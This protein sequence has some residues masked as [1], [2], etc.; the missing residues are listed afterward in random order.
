MVTRPRLIA[1][2]M[3]GFVVLDDCGNDSGILLRVK[4]DSLSHS[5]FFAIPMTYGILAS[6]VCLWS[7]AFV[8]TDLG[9]SANIGAS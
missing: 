6:S 4:Y 9:I 2:R 5:F 1:F 3:D 8:L 7:F